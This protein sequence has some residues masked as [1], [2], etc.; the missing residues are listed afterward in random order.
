MGMEQVANED[1][2]LASGYFENLDEV[3]A[4]LILVSLEKYSNCMRNSRHTNFDFEL[5]SIDKCLKPSNFK[6]FLSR[7][8]FR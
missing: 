4:Q 3:S 7:E 1:N 5:T 6:K 8:Y 2:L